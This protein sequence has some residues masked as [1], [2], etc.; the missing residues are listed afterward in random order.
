MWPFVSTT[1]LPY[2]HPSY[3]RQGWR[4][5]AKRSASAQGS[6]S[7]N[8]G[9]DVLNRAATLARVLEI[10]PLRCPDVHEIGHLV[11]ADQRCEVRV[12]DPELQKAH[13]LPHGRNNK[14]PG[15]LGGTT[16]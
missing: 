14:D 16:G 12:G 13:V 8:Q 7:S 11:L 4:H 5:P 2:R 1:C 6:L 3:L 15:G 10:E 9:H